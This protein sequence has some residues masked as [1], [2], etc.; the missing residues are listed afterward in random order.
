M[1][2]AR[3]Q[4]LRVTAWLRCG[5]ICDPYLPLDGI[6]LYQAFR[7]RHGPQ[8]R[9]LPGTFSGDV[10]EHVAMPLEIR[11][12]GDVWYYACSFAYPQPW[13]FAEG[14]DHW[15]KRF[16]QSYVSL[17]DFQGRRGKIH[18]G[19]G[20]YRSYHMPVFY[21]VAPKVTWYCV[22]DSK[23][24]ESLLYGV[25]HL[26]K[27]RSQGWGEVMEWEVQHWAHDWSERDAEGRLTRALPAEV[28]GGVPL[29]LKLYGLRPPYWDRQN[30]MLVALP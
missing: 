24:I 20:R 18:V 7:M 12:Q 10:E 8:V 13:W 25:S 1:D 3:F 5:I 17:V 6:L 11:G 15:N 9:T 2:S 30:Q 22:G 4:P 29:D 19:Q 28:N 27:K 26:G 14:Q 21:R 16:D 23:G